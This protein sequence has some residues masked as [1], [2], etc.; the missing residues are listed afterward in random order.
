MYRKTLA[1][2]S[3]QIYPANPAASSNA[4]KANPP[5]NI[6]AMSSTNQYVATKAAA[7]KAINT[8]PSKTGRAKLNN[9]GHHG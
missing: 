6:Q 7:A 3:D 9:R 4:H 5:Q 8:G 2:G 1:S